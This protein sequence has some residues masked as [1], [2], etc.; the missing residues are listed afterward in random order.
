MT[1]SQALAIV[2]EYVKNK[3]LVKHMLAVEAAMAAYAR[4]YG[5]DEELWRCVGLLHDFDWEIYPTLEG[6]PQKG[7]V[8][9]RARGVDETIIRAVLSHAPHTGISRDSLMEKSL[10][11][12]DELTGLIIAVT[13]VRPSRNIRDVDTASIQ[14][15]WSNTAFARGVN[16]AEIEQ[17]T[18]ELGVDLWTEHVPLVLKA[19]QP[20]A[21]VLGLGGNSGKAT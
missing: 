20:I 10:F 17:A 18:K 15:K 16:R 6:H 14:K 12:V 11:A 13:L 3:N 5:E 21:D 1:R 9:L 7:A 2:N 4:K 19:L 8:I